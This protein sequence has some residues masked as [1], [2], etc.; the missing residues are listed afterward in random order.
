MHSKHS[1]KQSVNLEAWARYI[2]GAVFSAPMMFPRGHAIE[3]SREDLCLQVHVLIDCRLIGNCVL[4]RTCEPAASIV[5]L[6]LVQ[7]GLAL[8]QDA[9]GNPIRGIL[10]GGP[11]EGLPKYDFV[12]QTA[13]Q[14][15]NTEEPSRTPVGTA[16]DLLEAD[17][18][19]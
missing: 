1:Y 16:L 13:R 9:Q 2:V 12:R 18:R 6:L 15:I 11:G 8:M 14:L 5:K 7:L 10:E 19:K 3:V 17:R 4:K